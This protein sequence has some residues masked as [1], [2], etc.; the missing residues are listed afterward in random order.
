VERGHYGQPDDELRMRM[1][2][3]AQYDA[4]AYV[5]RARGVETAYEGLLDRCRRKRTEWLLGVRLHLGALRASVQA[6]T[7]LRPLLNDDEQVAALVRLYTEA[8][9]PDV[10]M[11]GPTTDRGRRRALVHLRASVERFNRRWAAFIDKVDLSELNERRDGYNR[12]YLLEKECA[13]GP[14]RLL[15][16]SFA[17]LPP[18]TKADLLAEMPPL[19]LP[20]LAE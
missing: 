16:Q 20:R 19:P 15:P 5:R 12:Y 17:K 1:M 10:R 18:L 4:P 3:A 6:W 8:G 7:D 9:V 14:V 13:V 2:V 11:E